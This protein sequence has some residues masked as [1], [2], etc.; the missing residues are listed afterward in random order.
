MSGEAGGSLTKLSA[1]SPAALLLLSLLAHLDGEALPIGGV[2]GAG[3]A[4][5]G[6]SPGDV[7]KAVAL[8][9]DR[10]F[11][12]SGQAALAVRPQVKALVRESLPMAEVRAG[13]EAAVE[14]LLQLFPEEADDFVNWSRCEPLAAPAKAALRSI[15]ELGAVTSAA[16]RLQARLAAYLEDV[17]RIAEARE[18]AEGARAWV[19][20]VGPPATVAAAV[21]R[22]LAT[23]LLDLDESKQAEEEAARALELD[24]EALEDWDPRVLRDRILLSAAKLDLE[25]LDEAKAIL[26][27]A[28][29]DNGER[30]PNRAT[31]AARRGLAWTML[32]RQS[33]TQARA[34]YERAIAETTEVCGPSHPSVAMARTG[35]GALLYET[36][37][38]N[39]SFE[40]QRRALELAE[41]LLPEGHPSLAVVRSNISDS[42]RALGRRNEAR[43]QLVLALEAAEETFPPNHSSVWIRLRKLA[44]V[45]DVL[46]ENQEAL[47]HAGRALT[48]AEEAFGPDD[49]RVAQD[50]TLVARIEAASSEDPVALRRTGER[51]RRAYEIAERQLG[52][53]SPTVAQ[54]LMDW[55]NACKRLGELRMARDCY[56]R[57]LAIYEQADTQERT[58]RLRCRVEM[59]ALLWDLGEEGVATCRAL[60]LVEEAGRLRQRC[61]E[62]VGTELEAVV[63]ER[64][65]EASAAAAE[66]CA[67]WFPEL[68][69]AALTQ[70]LEH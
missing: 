17:G 11:I 53:N 45:L 8:L 15:G 39:R 12:E 1:D 59:A 64:D 7:G 44:S 55:G 32:K 40:E 46:D 23:V 10:G 19:D 27:R 16:V 38:I 42:L 14:L 34:Q 28:L 60:G 29:E 30:P 65:P 70:A 56:G 31:C 41:D 6:L 51:Y 58:G 49:L 62:A 67:P 52:P 2:A 50:L 54:Y 25:E 66:T 20:Q 18:L 24:G 36:G 26:E 9:E 61:E 69:L 57:A 5:R 63:L 22:A 37:E 33:R 21:H 35:F 68:A 48:I 43:G 4:P 3:A 47:R 13:A